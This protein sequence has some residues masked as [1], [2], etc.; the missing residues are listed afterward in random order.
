[1]KGEEKEL[2]LLHF[3]SVFHHFIDTHIH[4][5]KPQKHIFREREQEENILIC[6]KVFNIV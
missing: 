2:A 5:K 3:K 1:M 4:K 6:S